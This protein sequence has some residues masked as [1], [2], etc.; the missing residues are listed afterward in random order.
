M[1]KIVIALAGPMVNIILAFIALRWKIQIAGITAENIFYGNIILAIFNLLPIYPLD[2]GRI[3]KE[4][5]YREKGLKK[6]IELI[7]RVSNVT[8]WILTILASIGILYYK[9]IAIL[10]VVLYLWGILWQENKKVKQKL[11]IYEL[12]EK[13]EKVIISRPILQNQDNFEN[14]IEIK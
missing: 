3:L 6:S 12:L 1:K 11:R 13:E 10:V 2:G 9:N 14:S 4:V 7:N 5:F 8:V